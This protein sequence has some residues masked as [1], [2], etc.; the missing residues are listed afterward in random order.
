MII[1]INGTFGVGKTS[2]ARALLALRPDARLWDPEYV[3]FMLQPLLEDLPVANFQ[4][5]R[6]WRD[7]AIAT[8]AALSRQTNQT[9]V[10]P[11]SVLNPA[12]MREIREGLA[13]AGEELF[14]V[15][16][17]VSEP[18]LLARIAGDAVESDGCRDWRTAHVAAYGE[19]RQWMIEA[20]D[21]VVDTTTLTPAEV[22]RRVADAAWSADSGS[23]RP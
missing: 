7:I 4:D 13:A 15:V 23:G 5:W 1:W 14:E 11:Q 21:L 10:A 3:G 12:Y 22:A 19:S 9:L 6:A 17:D 2:T 18:V 8:G 16:L 20:A